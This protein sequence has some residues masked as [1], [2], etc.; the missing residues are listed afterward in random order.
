MRTRCASPLAITRM[1]AVLLAML[2]PA[3]ASAQQV[4]LFRAYL[5]LSGNDANPCTLPSPCRLLPKALSTVAAGGEIWMLDSANFNTGPVTIDKAV[6]ILAIPGAL[7][8]VVASGPTALS[9]ATTG[10]VTLR[11]L[12]ILPLPGSEGGAG[13]SVIQ[14]GTVTV[15]DCNIAG[16]KPLGRGL[17]V[18]AAAQVT[19]LGGV[20]RGNFE[21]IFASTGAR[22]SVMDAAILDS[23]VAVQANAF[24]PDETVHVALTRSKVRSGGSGIVAAASIGTGQVNVDV[25]DSRF[26]DLSSTAVAVAALATTTGR[27]LLSR[28]VITR[29]GTGVQLTGASGAR[30][31]L[32]GNAI[33][34]NT[35]GVSISPVTTASS[36]GTNLIRGNGT[37]VQGSLPT[38][39]GQ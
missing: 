34:G 25:A 1:S 22:V 23:S 28:S 15:Q 38:A 5:S 18:T 27:L 7:G 19:V 21:A 8:S 35:T 20:L 32:T 16:F 24:L 36:D 17:S 14:A 39:P 33:S 13:I 26:E 10:A 2:L 6:T 37:D 9:V 11:N 4:G 30:A 12:N 29:S 3:L 31:Y